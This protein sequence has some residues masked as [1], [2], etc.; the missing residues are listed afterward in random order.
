MNQKKLKNRIPFKD[1][2]GWDDKP[3]AHHRDYTYSL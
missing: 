2:A 3:I 1:M